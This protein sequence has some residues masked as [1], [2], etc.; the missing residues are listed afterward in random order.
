MTVPSR[1]QRYP[2][3]DTTHANPPLRVDQSERCRRSALLRN[4]AGRFYSASLMS[5]RRIYRVQREPSGHVVVHGE[6]RRRRWIVDT[7]V[8][9]FRH[10]HLAELLDRLFRYPDVDHAERAVGHR[11]G[12]VGDE[13]RRGELQWGSSGPAG[14]GFGRAW[15][16]DWLDAHM[17]NKNDRHVYLQ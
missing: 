14:S 5:R 12:N 10:Q 17:V 3:D 7:D 6:D 9:E 15:Y 11:A 8:S 2:D 4:Q 13:P 16:A 1:S